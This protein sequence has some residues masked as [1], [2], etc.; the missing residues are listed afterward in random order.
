MTD[1]QRKR[2][3]PKSECDVR[4]TRISGYVTEEDA[5]Y[6]RKVAENMGFTS[7]S[8]MITAILERLCIGGFSPAVFLKLGWQFSNV[9]AKKKIQGGF[10]FVLRPLPPLLGKEP[11]SRD[12][13]KHLDSMK[14]EL[15]EKGVVHGTV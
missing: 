2:G 11:N 13:S 15:D 5:V 12:I 14:Q 7:T 4:K 1:E 6:I 9:L 8:E 10:Y 3:R